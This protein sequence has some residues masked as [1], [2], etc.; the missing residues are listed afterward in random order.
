MKLYADYQR[1]NFFRRPDWRFERVLKLCD[2]MPTPG[3]CNRRDDAYVKATRNFLLRWRGRDEDGRSEL[4]Y[5]SPGLYYAYEAHEK[6][7]EDPD[8]TTILETRLLT[9]MPYEEIAA[10]AGILP[11][12]VEWYEALFFN[13]RDRLKQRDWITK[14]VLI[15]AM[16]RNFGLQ[17]AQPVV[18]SNDPDHKAWASQVIARPFL[19]AS[20]KMFAYFGGTILAEYLIHNFQLGKFCQSVDDIPRFLDEHWST[21][22]RVRSSQSART[23]EV[24]KYN[25]IELFMTHARIIEVEK[26][27]ESADQKRTTMERHIGA[28][29]DEIPWMAGTD[30][31]QQLKDSPVL[32]Y[33]Q[34]AAELRDDELLLVASGDPVQGID[35]LELLTLPAPT[36]KEN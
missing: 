14:Q 20:L 21:T 10:A 23:F 31:A 2:R 36:P 22:I 11:Q 30:G 34:G 5:E 12:A 27:E 35:G 16:M 15:P 8:A 24:N 9:T 29:L 6:C 4:F 7:K 17:N 28:M 1:Y 32:K 26:S 3:R 25:V 13:V 19:D 18:A 33:D